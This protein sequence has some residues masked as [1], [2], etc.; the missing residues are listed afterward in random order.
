M[1][2]HIGRQ[3]GNY[4]LIR[5]LGQGGFA[6]V[7]LGEHIYLKTPAAIKLL[8]T[9]L[10]NDDLQS[11][12]NEARSIANLVH[13]N[14]VR[15]LEFGVEG[16][17][18]FLVMDY[19]P[20]GTLRQRH[21]RGSQ[22]LPAFIAR[23]IKQVAA[24]LQYAHDQR[25]IHRDIKPENILLGRNNEV[26]LSDFGIAV[27]AQSSRYHQVGQ[28]IGGT[29][30]YMAPE[31]LQGRAVP[32]SDQYA[33]GIVTY[34]W[35]SG[36]RPFQ[37]SFPEIASQHM[38]TPPASLQSKIPGF[39]KDIEEVVMRALAK[40]P[41]RRF[42]RVEAFANALEQA[43]QG[44]PPLVIP[45][46]QPSPFGETTLPAQSP[47]PN[48]GVTPQNQFPSGNYG[49]F[50]PGQATPNF[51]ETL[52]P[53][54]PPPGQSSPGFASMPTYQSPPA[55]GSNISPGQFSPTP[56]NG[57]NQ[58]PNKGIPRRVVVVG[59]AGL[60]G[61]VLVGG[62]LS[63]LAHSIQSQNGTSGNSTTSTNTTATAAPT[64][65]VT[66]APTDTP[67]VDPNVT[68]TSPPVPTV[69]TTPGQVLYVANWSSGLDGWSGTGDWKSL[70]GSLLND[71][72]NGD[73]INSAPTILVPTSLI[74]IANYAVEAVIQV[75]SSSN[76]APNFGFVLRAA[77]A[78]HG[79]MAG[80]GTH[81]YSL[82]TAR[83]SDLSSND[84]F[85][86]TRSSP[87]DPGLKAHTYRVE[88]KDNDI[89]LLIDGG[90]AV[91]LFDNKYLTGERTGLW[92]ANVQLSIHSYKVVAL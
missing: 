11:F 60:A 29:I 79:Y 32:A 73:A 51:S 86:S 26:L 75:Q 34:E 3:L 27:V 91:E 20:N 31:Q 21:P 35:L 76:Y 69:H 7:Y 89:K 15:V 41:Q 66:A 61:V 50:P 84:F 39:P 24:A 52:P 90:L 58:P 48:I 5:L 72:T 77:D 65:T 12:L 78:G 40:D 9:R 68:P 17:T 16:S 33:L 43:C 38:L 63:F 83:I 44:A 62:G 30:A 81:D 14:I 92:C 25:V 80:I 36:D 87:F 18:P 67:T 37:G 82:N 6:D 70:N 71:G 1:S 28:E 49:I 53:P 42:M 2:D 57:K 88:I 74:G 47:T 10:A 22:I 23:Y 4:R 8:Q 46:G 45:S 55:S 64:D 85:N 19:A 56:Q 59:L 54:P 13:P